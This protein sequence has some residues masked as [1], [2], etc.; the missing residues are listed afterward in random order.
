MRSL[1]PLLAIAV[2]GLFACSGEEAPPIGERV[3]TELIEVWRTGD[4]IAA[5]ELLD[6]AVTW[7]DRSSGTSAL[8]F[9]EVVEYL[10]GIHTWT[11][12]LFVDAVSIQATDNSASVE[13][14][15]EGVTTAIDDPGTRSHFR[16]EGVTLLEIERGR[17]VA[18]VDYSS[19]LNL[20]LARGGSV[21]LPDG[22]VLQPTRIDEEAGG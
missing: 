9:P 21:T 15:M 12:S 6:P 19:P 14:I 8:G 18:A 7:D 17:I 2:L 3:A 22:T 1:R 10:L 16:V 20:I 4:R 11:E 13:W 5:E